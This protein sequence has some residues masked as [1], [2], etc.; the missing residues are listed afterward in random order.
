MANVWFPQAT[1][2]NLA[3]PMS[4]ANDE[5]PHPQTHLEPQQL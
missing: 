5:D 4:D 2:N 1:H 3:G